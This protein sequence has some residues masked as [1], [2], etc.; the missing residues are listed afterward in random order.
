MFENPLSYP[1]LLAIVVITILPVARINDD[2]SEI[3][4]ITSARINASRSCITKIKVSTIGKTHP[5]LPCVGNDKK[6]CLILF[7]RISP[8]R[9]R[10]ESDCCP[11]SGKLADNII[12]EIL[13]YR[14]E[15][16]LKWGASSRWPSCPNSLT[17]IGK[18]HPTLLCK[19]R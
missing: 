18:T 11:N 7:L 19:P 16:M 12:A 2:E 4:F 15:T 13:F 5:T 3:V 9:D 14:F 8:A 6:Y 1:I 10:V 17:I